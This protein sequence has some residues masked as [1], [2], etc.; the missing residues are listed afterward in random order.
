MGGVGKERRDFSSLK[1]I[2]YIKIMPTVNKCRTIYSWVHKKIDF[3][4]DEQKGRLNPS[5]DKN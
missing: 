4:V 1:K 2:K 5:R 3:T